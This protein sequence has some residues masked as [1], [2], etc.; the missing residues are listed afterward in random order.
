[1][2]KKILIPGAGI[3]Q[4]IVIKKAKEMGLTTVVVSPDGDYPGLQY[5]DIIY[6]EDVR[7]EKNVLEIARKEKIAG[8]ASDQNNIPV[9]TIGYVAESLNLTG[10]SYN[11]S[12][13]YSRKDL[14]REKC[15]EIGVPSLAYGIAADL[16]TALKMA[17]EIGYPLMCKPTDNQS[18][19]GI[20]KVAE[21]EELAGVFEEVL[22]HS[23]S[24]KIILEQY[25][26]GK[27]YIVDGLAIGGAYKSLIMLENEN[28]NIKGLYVPRSRTSPTSLPTNKVNE[29]LAL[30]SL[31]NKSFGL[32]NGF[33]HNEYLLN[34]K[35]DKFYLIDSAA[36]G[37]GA[38]ISSHLTPYACGFDTTELLIRLALG[39]P[40]KIKD[41]HFASKAVCYICF[42]LEEGEIRHIDGLDKMRNMDCVLGIHE[43]NLKAGKKVVGLVDK[44]HR[45]GP[46]LLGCNT[47]QQLEKVKKM[48]KNTLVV[49]TDKNSNAII[50]E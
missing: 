46:I 12:K 2:A 41:Y 39:E 50:W 17:R 23:F 18:S 21:E 32:A 22:S 42:Y 19:K 9:E 5:A 25:V 48:I 27:E 24:G 47:L 7:N 8:I 29:L 6:H 26:K 36:R 13:I 31:I 11:T 37:G 34:P 3:G 28:F 38:F 1:M 20:F 40:L 35:D 45:L 15:R 44:S 16:K 49:S 43:V 10:N 33:S 14:M 4:V 30:D